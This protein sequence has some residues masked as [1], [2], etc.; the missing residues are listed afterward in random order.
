MLSESESRHLARVLRIAEGIEVNAH[1][2]ELGAGFSAKVL[3]SNTSASRI[4]IEERCAEKPGSSVR[5]LL[6]MPKTQACELITEK[7][8]ELGVDSIDYFFAE[9][10]QNH[11]SAERFEKRLERL[12]RIA[13]AAVKQS[14]ASQCPHMS[15][16]PGLEDTLAK[17]HGS[18]RGLPAGEHRLICV[19]PQTE[20][21]PEPAESAQA[22]HRRQ[23]PLITEHLC[24]SGM[25][26]A[27]AGDFCG[28]GLEKLGE[29]VDL[30]LLIGPEGGFTEKELSIAAGFDYQFVSL[31]S[32][33]LRSETAAILACGISG[34]L[35]QV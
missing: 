7:S 22:R 24:S 5:L 31:G 9:R 11:V 12:E 27:E 10:S 35:R 33:V 26:L 15:F 20:N 13:L 21:G 8:V 19:A 3:E 25:R 28:A 16:A 6:G 30:Y 1:C 17:L 34:F 32:T 29:S 14:Y 2:R 18:A 4:R 23:P